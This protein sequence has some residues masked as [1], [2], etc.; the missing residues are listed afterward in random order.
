MRRCIM[1]L[2]RRIQFKGDADWVK[3]CTRS[4]VEGT[5][6]VGRPTKTWQNTVSADMRLL[7]V[8]HLGT[9]TTKINRGP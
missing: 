5:S 2:H 3:A 4:L 7:K 1:R 9:S 6:P 8:D